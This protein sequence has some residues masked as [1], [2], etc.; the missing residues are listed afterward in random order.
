V[1]TL[2]V[3]TTYA[4]DEADTPPVAWVLDADFGIFHAEWPW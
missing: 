4:D 3:A 1:V 2:R